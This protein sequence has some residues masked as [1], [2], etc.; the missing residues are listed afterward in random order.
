MNQKI[1][2]RMGLKYLQMD[3]LNT[4]FCNENFNVVL[5]KGTLDALMPDNKEETHNRILKYF[6][7]I[8][9][10]TKCGGRYICIS[11]LQEHILSILLDYFPNNNWMFRVIRCFEAE[12]AAVNNGERLMPVFMV[13]CT[14]F[15]LLTRQILEVNL[16]CHEKMQRFDDICQVKTAISSIQHAVFVC[17][18]LQQNSISSDNEICLELL[19][20]ENS[21][22][23]Y[24]V[25]AVDNL[26]EKKNCS[27]AVFIVPQGRE[28][29]WL[30]S[31]ENGRKKLTSISKCNRLLVVTMHRNQKYGT[32]EDVQNELSDIIRDLTPANV[33]TQKVP[34][35]SLG[36]EG[37]GKRTII[38]EGISEISGGY[39]VEDVEAEGAKFRRLYFLSNQLVIQSEAKLKEYKNRK[40]IVK[41]VADLNYL[42]CKH[43]SPMILGSYIACT[44]K[45]NS[46]VA[47]LGVG[48]GGLC[49]FLNKFLP[50]TKVIGVEIDPEMI[51]IGID[52]FGLKKNDQ[53]KIE[54]NDGL[55]FLQ[56]Y[57]EE[58]QTLSAVLFDVD[59]K[60]TSIGMSCPPK[61]FLEDE[62]L[63]N[64]RKI[65]GTEGFFILN[66]VLR[67]ESLRPHIVSKLVK[68]FENVSSYKV[69]EELN[70]IF[71]CGNLSSSNSKNKIAEAAKI[72]NS[73]FEKH[74]N[75]SCS[76]DVNLFNTE[77][78]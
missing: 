50:A 78:E 7:E 61:E 51:K 12:R 35:L 77:V 57:S 75:E 54:V 37:V 22:P 30:F 31:T 20:M 13:I 15:N 3:V 11:L 2:G 66:L 42:T 47:I 32:L 39:I 60:D 9:R 25:Y 21:K 59:S 5:D 36:T 28:S 71:I 44:K 73:F 64:I 29:E 34:C 48:G 16:N 8:Q 72:L 10:I 70:E 18:S 43:H 46:S 76:I 23:K 1:D 17:A 68:R 49:S 33:K 27:Y 19:E 69:E 58:G 24:T 52:W 55:K 40:G 14:K 53:L 62:V 4:S 56:Q 41:E 67:E 65:V 45:P 38:H 63:D 6:E 26:P 74:D